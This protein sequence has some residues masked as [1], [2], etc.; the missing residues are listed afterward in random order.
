MVSFPLH[1]KFLCYLASLYLSFS[2][3]C[4]LHLFCHIQRIQSFLGKWKCSSMLQWMSCSTANA[5]LMGYVHS[6]NGLNWWMCTIEWLQNH[7]KHSVSFLSLLENNSFHLLMQR[8]LNKTRVHLQ[9]GCCMHTIKSVSLWC[10][11]LT[12]I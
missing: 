2:R 6:G 7:Q 8:D 3:S 10:A 4:Y 5:N 9:N 12:I 11:K 1:S